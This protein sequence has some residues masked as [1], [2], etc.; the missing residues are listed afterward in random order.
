MFRRDNDAWTAAGALHAPTPVAN[1]AFGAAVGVALDYV[2]ISAPLRDDNAAGVNGE[3]AAGVLP[4]SGTVYVFRKTG[5]DWSV[6]QRLNA[7]APTHNLRFGAAIA[8]DQDRILVASDQ[9]GRGGSGLNG[10]RGAAAARRSGAAWLFGPGEDDGLTMV[11][12][13]KA[14]NAG[15]GD[16]FGDAVAISE[17]CVVIGARYEDSSATGVG[18]PLD[19]DDALESGAVYVYE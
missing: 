8:V 13:I 16:M 1:D 4:Q 15:S 3:P 14:N 5:D 6:S 10:E 18:M 12:D 19:N 7:A 17:R 9:D 2:A 11:A